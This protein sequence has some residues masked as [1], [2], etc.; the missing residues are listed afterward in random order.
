MLTR[1]HGRRI[2]FPLTF[3]RIKNEK[4]KYIGAAKALA[5]PNTLFLDTLLSLKPVRF[6]DLLIVFASKNSATYVQ[7]YKNH[8]ESIISHDLKHEQNLQKML[9]VAIHSIGRKQS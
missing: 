8:K 2:C 7:F 3:D 5:N 9:F 1:F 6:P 4:K